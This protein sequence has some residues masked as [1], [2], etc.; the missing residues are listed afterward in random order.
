MA[1]TS[2]ND[3]HKQCDND[4]HK[5]TSISL[6]LAQLLAAECEYVTCLITAVNECPL[7]TA[8]VNSAIRLM[9]TLR[10]VGMMAVQRLDDISEDDIG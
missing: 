2:K 8:P 1:A 10:H 7:S 3:E 6:P 4:Q 9:N 5:E